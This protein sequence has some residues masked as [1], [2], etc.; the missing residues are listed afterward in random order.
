M[1]ELPRGGQCTPT[2]EALLSQKLNSQLGA[3]AVAGASPAAA[4]ALRS[5]EQLG[6]KERGVPDCERAQARILCTRPLIRL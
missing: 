5:S 4:T 6:S 2:G 3:T 1:Q